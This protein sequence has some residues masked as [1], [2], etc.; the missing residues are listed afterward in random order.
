MGVID[1]K[2]PD[3]TGCFRAIK[4]RSEPLKK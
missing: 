1:P 3:E 2:R 4:S